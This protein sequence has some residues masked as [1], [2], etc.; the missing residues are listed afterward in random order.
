MSGEFFQDFYKIGFPYP[1][2]IPTNVKFF[3]FVKLVYCL[4]F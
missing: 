4:D 2:K 3:S 1:G